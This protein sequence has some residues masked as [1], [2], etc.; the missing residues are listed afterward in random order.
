MVHQG[1]AML[2]WYN[3]NFLRLNSRKN[4]KLQVIHVAKFA[5]ASLSLN[6]YTFQLKFLIWLCT[7][8]VVLHNFSVTVF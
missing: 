8:S 5:L 6:S 1:A 4:D 2:S 7:M 3:R